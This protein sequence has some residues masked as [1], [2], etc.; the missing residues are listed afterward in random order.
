MRIRV[1][2]FILLGAGWTI[3]LIGYLLVL[4]IVGVVF[5][6]RSLVDNLNNANILEIFVLTV[7][8]IVIKG[9]IPP[10]EVF[11]DS[12]KIAAIGTLVGVTYASFL[13]L[14]QFNWLIAI[15]GILV[16]LAVSFVQMLTLGVFLGQRLVKTR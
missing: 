13:G 10:V 5:P 12:I 7:S 14:H 3:C 4:L 16:F 8:W 1:V 9:L 11:A 15:L 2:G 6:N